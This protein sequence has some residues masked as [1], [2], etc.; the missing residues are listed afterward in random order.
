MTLYSFESSTG[1]PPLRSTPI[2]PSANDLTAPLSVNKPPGVTNPYPELY[3]ELS[4]VIIPVTTVLIW[5]LQSAFTFAT[6]SAL[7]SAAGC[8]AAGVSLS[9][10]CAAL[11]AAGVTVSVSDVSATSFPSASNGQSLSPVLSL[12]PSVASLSFPCASEK[13]SLDSLSRSMSLSEK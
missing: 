7:L 10:T 11:S 6:L 4:A 2:L 1:S 9:S 13:I 12:S 8:S 5:L 3:S